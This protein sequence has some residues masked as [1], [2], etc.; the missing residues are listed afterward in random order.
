M[1]SVQLKYM[2][3]HYKNVNLHEALMKS[4]KQLLLLYDTGVCK[5]TSGTHI[6]FENK[7]NKL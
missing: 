3:R 5:E 2:Y 1:F 4:K 6:E 7:Y